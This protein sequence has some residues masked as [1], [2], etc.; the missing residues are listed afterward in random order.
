MLVYATLWKHRQF[1]NFHKLQHKAE[2]NILVTSNF[3]LHNHTSDIDS[4]SELALIPITKDINSQ[5]LLATTA[6][7]QMQN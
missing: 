1:L 3:L 4:I 6:K 2:V 7:E 5:D